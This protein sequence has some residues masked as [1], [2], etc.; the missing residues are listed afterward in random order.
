[1]QKKNAFR[2]N[3]EDKI[4]EQNSRTREQLKE[5]WEVKEEILSEMKL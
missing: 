4:Q 5:C 1:M 3:P 2:I